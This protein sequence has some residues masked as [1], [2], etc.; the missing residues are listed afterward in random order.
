GLTGAPVNDTN[1]A[2]HDY[3]TTCHGFNATLSAYNGVL[4]A[5][6]GG[7]RGVTTMNPGTV[8][9]NDGG[10][11]CIICHVGSTWTTMHDPIATSVHT[12]LVTNL[13]SCT[14]N[15]HVATTSPYTGIGEAHN[16]TSCANCHTGNNNGGL[17]TPPA[18]ALGLSA[19]GGN[20]GTCHT[21][22]WTDTHDDNTT[23]VDHS[24]EVAVLA[25]CGSATAPCHDTTGGFGVGAIQSLVDGVTGNN[26]HSFCTDCHNA[27]GSRKITTIPGSS[28]GTVPAGGGD[29]AVCHDLWAFSD[30]SH[31]PT[32]P[33][34][35]SFA[36]LT[37]RSQEDNTVSG[38]CDQCHTPT[39]GIS[40]WTGVYNEHSANCDTC[41]NFT[42]D[43]TGDTGTPV[44]T[45]VTTV[46]GT[47]ATA[48]CTTCHTKK[49]W[50][51]AG[52]T[53]LHGGHDATAF[54]T[55]DAACAGCHTNAVNGT[56]ADIHG[57]NCLW[58]HTSVSGGYDTTVTAPVANGRDGN[59]VLAAT[60]SATYKNATCV[61]CHAIGG[62]NVDAG[63][64]GG[65]HHD[66]KTDNV[67]TGIPSTNC[68]I[69]CHAVSGHEGDHSL[70][71]DSTA[72]CTTSCHTG[73]AGGLT[74]APVNDTNG[75]IHDYC[76][77]CHGFNA[78]LSA[79]NGVLVAAPGG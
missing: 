7:S 33:N 31:H 76:T 52:G 30:H 8:A 3:C 35:V 50:S 39:G 57:D 54:P 72:D 58:C 25:S 34:Q 56:V 44:V 24:Q 32:G 17:V 65:I 12:T 79:Y 11:A 20:C 45:T 78:T 69:S 9:T 1:G 21:L 6:P 74:G 42:V 29:C 5:A 47:D 49:L 22:T 67:V 70:R 40:T 28:L 68:T 41:H 16:A 43:A 51:A 66:N 64:I 59:A 75:A 2:I 23:N 18:K 10:G 4:V 36:A 46:I 77:T 13:A 73:T 19:L 48:N 14:T 53:S 63:S 37:D 15:C 55:V 60:G 62:A 71:V 26:V 61:T 38:Q 27:D